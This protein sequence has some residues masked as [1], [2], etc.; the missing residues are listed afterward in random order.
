MPLT[1]LERALEVL[2][3]EENVSDQPEGLICLYCGESGF[4]DRDELEDHLDGHPYLS[5]RVDR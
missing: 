1:S 4:E 2:R 5:R 3:P